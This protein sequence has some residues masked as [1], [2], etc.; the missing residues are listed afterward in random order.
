MKKRD[1][2]YLFLALAAATFVFYISTYSPNDGFKFIIADIRVALEGKIKKKV[3]VREGL[4]THVKLSRYNNSDT[5]IFLGESVDSVNVGEIIL[6]EKNSPFFYVKG[7]DGKR[8]KLKY[9]SIPKS[10]LDDE[11]FPK[12]WKDS[13]KTNWKDVVID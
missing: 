8:K 7:K 6:K 5:L 13:C 12:K 4:I 10:I 3:A 2:L 11:G 1:L 9:V